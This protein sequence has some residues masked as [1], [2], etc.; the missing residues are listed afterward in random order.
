MMRA[1][2]VAPVHLPFGQIGAVS[3]SPL[4]DSQT[5]LSAEFDAHA[6]IFGLYA[7]TFIAGYVSVMCT[8]KRLPAQLRLHKRAVECLQ[9]AAIGKTDYEIGELMSISRSTVR[10]HLMNAMAKLDAVN[11]SQT[12][13]K[14]A[15]LGYI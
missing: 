13:L 5:D 10:F 6:S 14:A 15:Q 9:W 2:I 12:I 1:A 8:A 4:D 7:R 3:I 11:R